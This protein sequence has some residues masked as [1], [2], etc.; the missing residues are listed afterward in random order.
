MVE[1]RNKKMLQ[2]GNLVGIFFTI[3][4]N[5]LAVILPLNG[6][7][8]QSLS[9]ALPNLFVPAGLTFS[10]WSII[11]LLMIVFG[12]YQAR[13]LLKKEQHDTP[14][15]QSI[16]YLFMLSCAANILWI[17][18]WHYQY[19]SLSLVAMLILLLSL[20]AIYLKLNIGRSQIPLREKLGVHLLFSVYLGWITVATVANVTALLVS[21]NWDGFGIAAETW[22]ILVLAVTALITL[23]MLILRKDIAYSLVVI[24]AA[25]GIAIK[26]TTP[27]N[28]NTTV[29]M[30][31]EI[32]ILVVFIGI[33][34][35]LAM[36]MFQKRKTKAS[37]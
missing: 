27:P 32:V 29:A 25:L 16:G 1:T 19:V 35:V 2:A 21:I 18:C 7:S 34:Y 22:T 5:S 8:T 15:L 4:V 31:S 30:T 28:T 23:L 6:K 33:L 20:I 14:F 36:Y 9:D 3:V 12:I 26:R 37:V 11:Y 13:D 17:F 24:W 10:I